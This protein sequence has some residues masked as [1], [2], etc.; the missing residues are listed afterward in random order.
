MDVA[1]G[2][3]ADFRANGEREAVAGLGGQRDGQGDDCLQGLMLSDHAVKFDS[4]H[5]MRPVEKRFG[6]YIEISGP[7]YGIKCHIC[8][9]KKGWI[10]QARKRT[11]LEIWANI[12]YPCFTR[13]ELEFKR[14]VLA[15]AGLDDGLHIDASLLATII[16]AAQSG[17]G[18]R[19]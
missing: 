17:M 3:Q 12:K 6:G 18:V 16:E 15:R 14:E 2:L 13:I 11:F 1:A 9:P 4:C 7:T 10:F 5:G 8:L 19:H